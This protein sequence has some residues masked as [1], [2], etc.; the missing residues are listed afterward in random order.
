[1]AKMMKRYRSPA[2][3]RLGALLAAGMCLA[4]PVR[5]AEIEEVVVTAEKRESTL[6]DTPIAVTAV[7]RD[8]LEVRGI[9]DFAQL[10]FA[11]PALVFAEI[12]DMAQI[13]MRGVGVDISTMDAEPGVAM[14]A[15]GVYRGGLTSSSSLL[16]DLERIE[17]LRGPQGT[18]YGR[19]ST[20][21]GLNVISRLPGEAPAFDAAL[22]YGDYDRTRVE[23]SGDVPVVPGRL[24]VRGAVAYDQH[25]GYADNAF[26]GREEDDAES[27]FAK[28]AAVFTA[29]DSVELTLRGEYTDSKIGGPPFLLT[30]DHPVPP[31]LLSVGNPGGILSIPGTI[32]GPVSCADALGLNLSPPGVGSDDPRNLYSDG[33]TRFDRE[34]WGVS[35][36]VDWDVDDNVA[37]RS[38][39]S[40]FEIEQVGNQSNN[41]GVDI[42]Y[43]TDNFRQKNEEWSQEFTL[44]GSAGQL[45]WIGGIYY[46][47]SDINEAFRFTLPA[48]QAT[49]EAL[50]G[51]F[52]GGPPLP[53]GS[54]AFFG[55]R[56]DGTPSPIP[57]LDF[58]QIQ[59]LESVAAYGQGTYH[60]T[61]R[62]RGTAGVRWTR[63]SKDVTQT[64]ANN[65]GGEACRDIDLDDD[66]S[67][68][69]GKLGVD[70]DV[71]ADNLVYASA[72]TGFKA[73]GFN[74]GTCN[75]PYDPETLLAFEIGSKSR[76]LDNSLQLNLSAFYYDYEDLQA[77][78]FINNA[79][80]VQ[81]AADAKAYGVEFE[82]LWLAGANLR[83]DGS[84][85]LLDAEFKN[86]ESTDP[87]NPQVG[88]DCDPVTGLACLQDLS[89]N[90]LL[91]SPPLKAALTAEYDI[92]LGRAGLL[93]LRGEYSYTD[94]MY[95]TVF[96]NDFAKQPS[97]PLYNARVIWTPAGGSLAGLQV[98]GFVE[99]IGDEDFVMI[100][101][102]NATTG[103]TLTQYGPPRTWGVQLRYSL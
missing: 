11:V 58:Q 85:S 29:S 3:V 67:E 94:S 76:L 23:L 27:T 75:N 59:D 24:A 28:A 80:I 101:A 50:F 34:S 70:M 91:R 96:N 2:A 88:T 25:D 97:Y 73:G 60:F 15:D 46:Y 4:A 92:G 17:V 43:L 54:L 64:V 39:S 51:L 42:A 84:L 5:A 49:F 55:T 53:P 71:G 63:D 26:T 38:I 83:I 19:N 79:S 103:G 68:V 77:R 32:C 102:P 62:L 14:Y 45:D 35:A 18:L 10:Q 98:M 74:G 72:S 33:V 6:Q 69:T 7:T 61:D 37:L 36:T 95:H 99:N 48:L 81:N 30:D 57:F 100:H 56:L 12:A 31:L 90:D 20:G 86:F 82:W 44:S 66:W 87:L 93:T 13:T 78:L 40:Y 65:L 9:D 47:Q 89:G 8:E 1:M 41:D 22:L 16:F 52:A 21:G